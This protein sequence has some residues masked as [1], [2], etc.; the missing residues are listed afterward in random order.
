VTI[1]KNYIQQYTT[2]RGFEIAQS[3]MISTI[4]LFENLSLRIK[5]KE[6]QSLKN[7]T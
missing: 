4:M 5:D 6:M 3:K 1:I 7:I 2:K